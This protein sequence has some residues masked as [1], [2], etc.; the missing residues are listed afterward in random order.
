MYTDGDAACARTLLRR[1]LAKAQHTALGRELGFSALLRERDVGRAWRD[2]V[3]V[4]PYEVHEPYIHRA[5]AGEPDVLWPGVMRHFAVSSGTTS[6]GKRLPRSVAHLRLDARFGLRAGLGYVARYRDWGVL[7]GAH[8]TMPGHIEPLPGRPDAWVGEVSGLVAS[9]AP[10]VFRRVFQAVSDRALRAGSWESRLHRMAEEAV[11][12]DVRAIAMVPSWTHVFAHIVRDVVYART[13]R[14]VQTL[15]EVWPNLRLLISGGVALAAYREALPADVGPDVRYLETYGASEGFFSY[16]KNLDDPAM[17]LDVR[18]GIVVEFVPESGSGRRIPLE[19]VEVGG[20]Y[21]P[22]VTS[23][24]GLWAYPVGDV[25]TFSSVRPYTIRVAGRTAEVLDRYGE[26]VYAADVEAAIAD[27]CRVAGGHL[28]NYHVASRF[29]HARHR[30][31][32]QWCVAFVEPP[33]SPEYW[34]QCADAALCACNRHYAIRRH[35]GAMLPPVL[36]PVQ[37]SQFVKALHIFR[38]RVGMQTKVPRLQET[39][40]F[41]EALLRT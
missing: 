9:Q 13:G 19:D 21:I 38:A 18:S 12:R 15:K 10:A 6:A 25:I 22:V 27:A 7:G 37:A 34:M 28:A 16:Q 5:L 29:D 30:P 20:R 24:S 1:L 8:L 41:A 17:H 32:H 2:A 36:Y 33:A 26:A 39:P 35:S 40:A 11:Q 31:V 14:R 3:P 23:C 4:M